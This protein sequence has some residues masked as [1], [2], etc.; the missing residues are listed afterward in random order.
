MLLEWVGGDKR[1]QVSSIT[2]KFSR[3]AHSPCIPRDKQVDA[4][5]AGWFP[6]WRHLGAVQRILVPRRCSTFL[7][8][9]I[10]ALRPL[11]DDWL[12]VVAYVL[13]GSTKN[14]VKRMEN[15]GHRI[16]TVTVKP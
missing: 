16:N 5:F 8:Y 3:F 6:L 4:A 12:T 15:T 1:G 9:S 2:M 14:L 10:Y 7:Q 11:L 13:T